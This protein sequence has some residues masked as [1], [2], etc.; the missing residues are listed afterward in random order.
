MSEDLDFIFNPHS[1]AVVGA[2]DN[3]LKWGNWITKSLIESAWKGKVYPIN[4]KGGTVCGNYAYRK[5]SDV[6]EP[7]DLVLVGIPAKFVPDTVRQCVEKKVKG[8]VIIT[9]GFGETGKEGK[10]LERELVEMARKGGTRIV[11]PNCAGIYNSSAG[12]NASIVSFLKGPITLISQ[13]GNFGLNLSFFAKKRGLGFSKWI[14]FGNQADILFHEFLD[15]VKDDIDTKV[16]LVYMEGLK[17]GRDFL[18]VAIETTKSKP[19]IILKIGSSSAGARSSISHT[20]ALAGSNNV[21]DAAFKQ[22]GIIRVNNS[23]EL[24]DV[25]EAFSKCPLPKGNRI[26]ILSDGGG[27][28][29]MAADAAERGDL[30]VPLLSEET[31]RKL[32]EVIP[33]GAVHSLNNPVDFASE[34]DLWCFAKCSEVLLQDPNI[35]GVIICGGFGSYKDAFPGF[36]SVEEEISPVISQLQKKYGKP[37]IL[38]SNFFV[39]RPKSLEILS[40]QGVPVYGNVEIATK[41]MSCLVTYSKYLAQSKGER[42]EPLCSSLD[43]PNL[44]DR[45]IEEVRSAGRI[46]LMESEARAILR[47]F[48]LPNSDFGT[49]KSTNE[50]VQIAEEIGYPV[51]MKILSPEIIHKSDA[52]GVKLNLKNDFEV[53]NAFAEITNNAITYNRT[54]EIHGVIIEPMEKKGIEVVI[55]MIKDPTFGPT[56]M[57]GLGG[58]FV[59]ILKD[60]SFRVAPITKTD[61]REMIEQIKGF[62]I[63]GGMRG[64]KPSDIDALVDII[65]KLS[66]F[67][68]EVPDV[69]EVD[70]NPVLAL[71]EG[72]SIVD[73]RIILSPS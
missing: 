66:A 42:E 34:A 49:A 26:A 12:L 45:V 4:A 20:G 65:L 35:D 24:L 57:F 60:V 29:T 55:G 50:A 3:P 27:D 59:E 46:N 51:V 16:I 41:S 62:P 36:E 9:S 43:R 14:S 71:P 23:Y 70:L 40:E 39:E 33:T 48:S 63:L 37:I 31:R 54:A 6:D 67:G 61:A 1:V 11:G 7:V 44:V 10:G 17:N 19:M 32:R 8:I 30:E 15:Y 25:G 68:L 28:A 69:S 22:A 18:K 13:S 58:I 2:T 52:G 21:Y 38:E 53:R 47:E 72:A 56:V 64:Q 73:A 5:I